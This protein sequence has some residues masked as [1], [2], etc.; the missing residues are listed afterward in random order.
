MSAR[1]FAGIRP[2]LGE[3]VYV[4][5]EATVIGDVS[6]GEDSSVWPMSVIRGDINRVE[7]GARTNIQDG[8][9]LHVTHA[10]PHNP[11]GHPLRVGAEVT[12]GHH[13]ILHGC[14]VLDRCLIGMGST[15][16]DGALIQS[17][18]V[19]GAGSLVTPGKELTGGYLWL[20]RPARRIRPLDP[21]EVAY[22]RYSAA[23][24]VDLKDRYRCGE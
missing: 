16:M 3:R 14:T 18:V 8:S 22:L 11:G 15:V 19:L 9:V 1:A 7:I 6:I 12:V 17:E 23:H 5:P 4:A 21:D 24:Y 20:G 10:G 2:R 13:V